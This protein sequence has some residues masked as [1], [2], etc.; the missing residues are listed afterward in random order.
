M[1]TLRKNSEVCSKPLHLIS[2][3][4]ILTEANCETRMQQLNKL[5]MLQ[6]D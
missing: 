5:L 6:H 3:Y 4:H 1:L 2:N